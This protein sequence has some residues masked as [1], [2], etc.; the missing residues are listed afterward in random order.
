[1]N[2]VFSGPSGAG[3][4]TLTELLLRNSNYKKFTTCT[5]R[6]PRENEKNGFDYYFLDEKTFLDLVA[7]GKMHNVKK[8]G[9][10]YYGSFEKDMDN[11]KSNQDIIFQLT[12]DRAMEMKKN[13]PNTCLILILPPSSDILNFRRKDRSQER[14]QNDILNL[15]NSR[16][17]DYVIVNDNLV[18]TYH[19][20]LK[21]LSNFKMGVIQDDKNLQ[22]EQISKLIL[23]LSSSMAN[24]DGVEKVFNGEVAKRW[25][26]KAKYVTYYGP[27]NPIKSEIMASIQNG[28]SI[29]DIGCGSGKILKKIDE[30]VFGCKLTGLD[31][32]HD[33]ISVAEQKQFTGKN[34]IVFI[35]NDFMKYQ[36]M[37]R[38]DIIIF[39]Y[40]LHHLD[41]P[42]EALIKAKNI[43]SDSG[44]VIFSVPGS[45]Y[46]SEVF[47][48]SELN[49]RYSINDMDKIVDAA[50][51]FPI[52]AKRNK[53]L[54]QFNSYEMFINY[55]KSIGTYQKING[56]SNDEWNEMMNKKIAERFSR[57]RIITG[58]YLT[59]NC[60]DKAKILKRR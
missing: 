28:T 29:A 4:G 11:I 54:M 21:C 43:L 41:N 7:S 27:K 35:N 49:G 26:E 20:I 50:G 38:Y 59:Y 22:N 45:N 51:L 44:K 15:E 58:E 60:E 6:K 30:N 40:V 42:I 10:N 32:S 52:S 33:M 36:F 55:L 14:I 37:E 3:K 53:F 19:D 2:I 16:N 17:F 31:I 1:M 56:Y 48:A 34:K 25:D 39:S 18:D 46:L 13:N 12:P 24:F 23:E 8:Y 57:S 47:A 5:T 9:G